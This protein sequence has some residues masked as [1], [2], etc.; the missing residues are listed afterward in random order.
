ML[1]NN[2]KHGSFFNYQIVWNDT[3]K[4]WYAWYVDDSLPQIKS[5]EEAIK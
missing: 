1:L 5:V 3:E 2:R 4:K